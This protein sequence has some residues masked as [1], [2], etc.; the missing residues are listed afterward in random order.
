M[1]TKR[2]RRER[3]PTP[4]SEDEAPTETRIDECLILMGKNVDLAS[5][6]FDA[7]SFHIEGYFVSIGWVSI[8]TLDEKAY[9]NIM[10]EFYRYMIYSPG[11]GIT[12]IV[13]NKRIKITQNII[14]S[15]L[16]LEDCEIRLFISKMVSH[17]EGYNPVE[18]CCRVTGK[19]FETPIRL[20][21]NQ[22]TLSCRVLHN[23]IAHINVPRKG[24]LDE[25][26][27]FNLFLLDYIMLNHM[28]TIHR[29]HK[30]IA[31]SFEDGQ[32]EAKTK[33][34][35]AKLGPSTLP[36][37]GGKKMDEGDDDEDAPPP[38]HPRPSSHRPS[39]TSGFFFT[40]DHYNLLNGQI[41]SLTT[42][43]YN[44]HHSINGLTSLF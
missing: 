36:F 18:A 22:L 23:I 5:F 9:P 11:T 10:K 39:S 4:S 17:F 3:P 24:H 29:G 15:I 27:N 32:W 43:G 25:V 20:S 7:P 2:Q 12:C 16:E 37:E 8:I 31:L 42:T 38:S 21:P 30:V 28:K 1:A 19:H 34:F 35:D 40:K 14:R 26:N 13:K 6:T 41:D 44:L 33:G